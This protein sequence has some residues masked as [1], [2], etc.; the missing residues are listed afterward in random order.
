VECEAG[1]AWLVPNVFSLIVT[2]AL[3]PCRLTLDV[4]STT[5]ILEEPICS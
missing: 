1:C 4:E 5:A 3:N 2:Q